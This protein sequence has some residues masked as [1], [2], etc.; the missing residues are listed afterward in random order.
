M[1]TQGLADGLDVAGEGTLRNAYGVKSA[2]YSDVWFIAAEID[3][4]GMEGDGEVGIWVKNGS[5]QTFEGLTMSVD[6]IAN[7][8]SVWPD[9]RTASVKVSRNDDGAQEAA[10]CAEQ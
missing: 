5:L 9:G 8:M 7:N 10:A 6:G 2:D 4:P 1:V 3:G